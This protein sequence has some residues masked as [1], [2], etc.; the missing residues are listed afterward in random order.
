MRRLARIAVVI[1]GILLNIVAAFI[2][3]S[4]SYA[5]PPLTLDFYPCGIKVCV[6]EIEPNQTTLAEADAIIQRN[7]V[8]AQSSN[9]NNRAYK[10]TAPFYRIDL[11]ENEDSLVSEV[12]LIFPPNSDL[13]A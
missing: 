3:Y 12:D 4:R 5:N 11:V 6:L 9:P 1:F 7:S 13:T 8:F 10:Q 2:S